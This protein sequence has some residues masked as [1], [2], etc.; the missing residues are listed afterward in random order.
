MRIE[1]DCLGEF[2]IADNALYGLQ[3][4]R[5]RENFALDYKKMNLRLVYA[6]V[7]VKKA[8]ALSYLKLGI[9]KPGVYEA[10]SRPVKGFSPENTTSSSSSTRCRAARGRR[11]T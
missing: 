5:A 2:D 6:I 8:A 10:L 1:K 11:R 9:G 7:K 4:A 3:T